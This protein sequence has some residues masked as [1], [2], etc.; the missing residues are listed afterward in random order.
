[1]QILFV[2][3]LPRNSINN[4]SVNVNKRYGRKECIYITTKH[5][6]NSMDT[7]Y[8]ILELC[9]FFSK[10]CTYHRN[11]FLWSMNNNYNN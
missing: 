7:T 11:D 3:F 6:G 9:D 8:R 5:F 1:M 10:S 4:V 2:L